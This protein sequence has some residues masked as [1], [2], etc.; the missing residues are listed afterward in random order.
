MISHKGKMTVEQLQ[1][2]VES[3]EEK[4]GTY[5]EFNASK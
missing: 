5:G 3:K 1:N 4:K 2:S